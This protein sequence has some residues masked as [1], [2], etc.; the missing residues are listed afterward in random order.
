M[1]NVL[2][3]GAG[4]DYIGAG[5]GSNTM[6]GGAGNDVYYSDGTY[7][8]QNII[9]DTDGEADT[10]IIRDSAGLDSYR[11]YYT[12]FYNGE[13]AIIRESF[14]GRED[15][16][17]YTQGAKSIES[18]TWLGDVVLDPSF[19]ENYAHVLKIVTDV[20]EIETGHFVYAGSSSNDS[21][22]LPTELVPHQDN[23]KNFG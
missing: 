16:M 20:S 23:S 17:M 21:F 14:D 4:D 13:E 7:Q 19:Q 6:S 5:S 22:T 9:T 10:L 8:G 11:F 2:I 15:V 12:Q 3:S 1:G 18:L